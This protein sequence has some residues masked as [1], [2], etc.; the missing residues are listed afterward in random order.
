M[1][2]TFTIF[3]VIIMVFDF[4]NTESLMNIDKWLEEALSVQ[5]SDTPYLFLVGSKMDLMVRE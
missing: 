1:T 4:R 2:Q 5:E 3:T